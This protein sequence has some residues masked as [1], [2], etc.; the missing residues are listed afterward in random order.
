MDQ[1]VNREAADKDAGMKFTKLLI[2]A[3]VVCVCPLFFAPSARAVNIATHSF[4]GCNFP[5]TNQSTSYTATF[6]EDHDYSSSASTMSF[7][8]YNPVGVSSVTVDNRTGLMW[9]TNRGT[10]AAMGGSYTWLNALIACESKSYAGFSDWRVPNMRELMT[11]LDYSTTTAPLIDTT[12]FLGAISDYNWT[13]TTDAMSTTYAW[14]VSFNNGYGS[15]VNLKTNT[16]AVRCVRG[17]P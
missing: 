14:S 6:G 1:H 3:G 12:A 17:G 7:T 16:L 4:A 9:I 10:D 8:I 11:I 5:D 15:S 2:L 13:S